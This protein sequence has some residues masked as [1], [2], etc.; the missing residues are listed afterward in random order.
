MTDTYTVADYVADLRTVIA[1][2]DDE[3][4]I[5]QRVRPLAQKLVANSAAWFKPEFAVPD[6]KR[7]SALNVLNEDDDHSLMVFTGCLRP[8]YTS[9]VHDHG[10]WAV[11]VG[12]QGEECNT[13]YSRADD[14]SDPDQG[15]IEKRG[16][17]IFHRGDALAMPAGVY[18]TVSNRSDAVS[19]ALHTYGMSTNHTERCQIDPETG[20]VRDFKIPLKRG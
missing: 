11:V 9:Q 14:G 1:D 18:H 12:I 20:V 17:K 2:S 15:V 16:E 5:M 3:S 10:T 4:Q 7:G 13:M 19:V 8:D 6:P